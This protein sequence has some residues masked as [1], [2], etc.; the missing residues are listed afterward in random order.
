MLI[1]TGTVEAWILGWTSKISKGIMQ[2][3]SIIVMWN[4]ILNF[5]NISPCESRPFSYWI[6]LILS[7]NKVRC[8]HWRRLV[9]S[10]SITSCESSC[11]TC[12]PSSSWLWS[13]YLLW[14]KVSVVCWFYSNSTKMLHIFLSDKIHNAHLFW[15]ISLFYYPFSYWDVDFMM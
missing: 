2:G 1:E 6:V 11:W 13:N 12:N 8:S 7:N 4:A 5:L 15:D 10:T 14:W 9:W 3:N